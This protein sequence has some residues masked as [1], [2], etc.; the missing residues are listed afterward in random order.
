MFPGYLLAV[1]NATARYLLYFIL[2]RAIL[3]DNFIL[4][5]VAA[6]ALWWEGGG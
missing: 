5:A 4:C 2:Y 3:T 6:N 1:Y